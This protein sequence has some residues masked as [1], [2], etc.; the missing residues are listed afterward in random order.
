[1]QK[2]INTY[3]RMGRAYV[4]ENLSNYA[5]KDNMEFIAEC[6]AEYHS[7]KNPRPI[8]VKVVTLLRKLHNEKMGVSNG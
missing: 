6:V 7:C 4:K 8:A 3:K 5:N 2:L 1:M